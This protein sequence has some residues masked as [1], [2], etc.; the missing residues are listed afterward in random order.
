[1][2]GLVLIHS[3]NVVF[4]DVINRHR[5]HRPC[6]KRVEGVLRRQECLHRLLH[7]ATHHVEHDVPAAG[8]IEDAPPIRVNR[9]ALKVHDLVIFEEVLPRIEMTLF[10]FLLGLFDLF[11]H[12]RMLDGLAFLHPEPGQHAADPVPGKDPHQVVFQ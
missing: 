11:G 3:A 5:L 8:S 4:G 9:L 12:H 10:D 6:G 1:M 2:N 7:L